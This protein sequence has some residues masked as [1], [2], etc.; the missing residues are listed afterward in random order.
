MTAEDYIR[1]LSPEEKAVLLQ[2][3]PAWATWPIHRLLLPE[4]RFAAGDWGLA[5][6]PAG[7][8]PRPATCF[9]ATVANSFDPELAEEMGRAVAAEAA[10]EGIHAL[11]MSVVEAHTEVPCLYGKLAAGY[12]RGIQ[13]NGVVACPRILPREIPV[14][15]ERAL[16]EQT[17]VAGEIAVK[18]GSPRAVMVENKRS[19]GDHVGDQPRIL[20]EILRKE[21]G[22]S[23]FVASGYAGN[24]PVSAIDAGVAL[25]MPA[26][27]LDNARYVAEAIRGGKLSPKCVDDRLGELLPV[28]LN[29]VEAVSAAPKSVDGDAYHA[30]AKKCAVESMVLL[31]NDGVLPLKS[32]Q[33]VLI[34]DDT[35]GMPRYQPGYGVPVCPTRVDSLPEALKHGDVSVEC[36]HGW[37][38]EAE[39]PDRT[40]NRQAAEAAKTADVVLLC[41]DAMGATGLPANQVSL[42]RAVCKA[43][44]HVVLVLSGEAAALPRNPAQAVIFTGFA[45]QAVGV[46]LAELLLGQE[47][48]SGRLA[49]PWPEEAYPVGYGR[50]YTN[51]V[52]SD[53]TADS[54]QVRFTLTNSGSMD[55]AEV[56]QV[57]I[58]PKLSKLAQ[59]RREMKAFRRVFLKAGESQSV[60]IPLDEQAFR[61]FHWESGTWEVETGH[62][63]IEVGAS[64]TDVRLSSTIRLI[65]TDAPLPTTPEEPVAPAVSEAVTADSPLRLLIQGKHPL[66][67]RLAAGFAK[68]AAVADPEG[69]P[70]GAVPQ[71]TGGRFGRDM[72]EDLLFWANGHAL[73]GGC[74]LLRDWFRTRKAE[75]DFRKIL[76]YGPE[77]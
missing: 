63:A 55:G 14:A 76:D 77:E 75:S 59:P 6:D 5:H 50:S 70:I 28:I 65:G 46:A 64:E 69:L 11:M 4:M 58:C 54:R 40:L 52:Y 9:P 24:D 43:S 67:G 17:L 51:F 74:R 45:G 73:R 10:A 38:R 15:G 8:K 49:Q 35:S 32:G 31:E 26:P 36:V 48:S 12:I 7:G 56:A 61:Y 23:G 37:E 2:S 68:R 25:R 19:G 53:L 16:R 42:L 41:L 71:L 29:A 39:K 13:E 57:Y 44:D 18:E 21:W 1:K 3:A 72:T 33:K 34:I 60:T 20:Q 30:L 62:Y 66:L 47:N 22:F 27:G